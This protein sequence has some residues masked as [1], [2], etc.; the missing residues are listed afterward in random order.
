MS[1][2]MPGDTPNPKAE[3]FA[4]DNGGNLCPVSVSTGDRECKREALE[5]QCAIHRERW[6]R[7]VNAASTAFADGFVPGGDNEAVESA[8]AWIRGAGFAFRGNRED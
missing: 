7:L 1:D 3:V 2:R 4:M 8:I 6:Q 5:E